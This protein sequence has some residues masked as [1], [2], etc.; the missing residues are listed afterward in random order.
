MNAQNLAK[1]AYST[2]APIRTDR[3]TEYQAFARITSR[4]KAA[5]E[6][7]GRRIKA[8]AQTIHENRKLWKI[9]TIDLVDE[10]NKLPD[11][12]RAQLLYLADFTNQHS[13]KVLSGEGKMDILIEINTAVMRGLRGTQEPTT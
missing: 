9:L 13:S 4:M 8:I 12:L 1:S 2:T 10:N 6:G 3:A 7:R 5:S 11:Q